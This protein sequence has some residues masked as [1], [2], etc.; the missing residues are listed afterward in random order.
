MQIRDATRADLPAIHTI[1]QAE[2][3][4]VSELSEDDLRWFFEVAACLRVAEID[5]QPAGFLLGLRPGLAYASDNYRWFAARYPD[6]Y[7]IDRLAVA[8]SFRRRGV[9]SALYADVEHH[10]CVAGAP[11]LACEVNVRPRNEGS[12]GFHAAQGFVEVGRQDTEGGSKTVTM[13]VRPV[14]CSAEAP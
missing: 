13:L 12:L 10:A 1:N 6:F 7:Y 2:V 5:R 14:T 11:V 3:P 8:P 4:A 9:A